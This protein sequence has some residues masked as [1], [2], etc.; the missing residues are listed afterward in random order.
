M[1]LTREQ[2]VKMWYNVRE[3]EKQAETLGDIKRAIIMKRVNEMKDAIQSVI[4][5]ME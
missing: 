5:Q 3:I 1:S 4:G 2:W